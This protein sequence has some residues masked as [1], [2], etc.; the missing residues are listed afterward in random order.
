MNSAGDFSLSSSS[1]MPESVTGTITSEIEEWDDRSGNGSFVPSTQTASTTIP[2]GKTESP[3]VAAH[4]QLTNLDRYRGASATVSMG[5]SVVSKSG[6]GPFEFSRNN[7]N[8]SVVYDIQGGSGGGD[9][10][11]AIKF[12]GKGKIGAANQDAVINVTGGNGYSGSV[13]L[14][15]SNSYKATL[16]NL[17]CGWSYTYTASAGCFEATFDPVSILK[18]NGSQS[19]S[20]NFE[21][22]EDCEDNNCTINL[23]GD[24]GFGGQVN[25][26]VNLSGGASKSVTLSSSNS[27]K[28]TWSGMACGEKY[29]VSATAELSS[30]ANK[31]AWADAVLSATAEPDSFTLNE[32]QD[33]YIKITDSAVQDCGIEVQGTGD[34]GNGVFANI[35]LSGGAS[36]TATLDESNNYLAT[37]TGLTCGKSYTVSVTKAGEKKNGAVTTTKVT[38]T[39]NPSGAFT[40]TGQANDVTKYVTV[41]FKKD[42][43]P[44]AIK[45]SIRYKNQIESGIAT[46]ASVTLSGN[47][48]SSQTKTLAGEFGD[49]ITFSDLKPGTYSLSFSGASAGSG[50]CKAGQPTPELSTTSPVVTAG[51]TTEV[52][53]TYVCPD[54]GSS[55]IAYLD[56]GF[57]SG[58]IGAQA[59]CNAGIPLQAFHKRAHLSQPV[60]QYVEIHV[61]ITFRDGSGTP[62]YAYVGVPISKGSTSGSNAQTALN[63][64]YCGLTLVGYEIYEVTHSDE[65][66]IIW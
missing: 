6:D 60:S 63:F 47:G 49:Y 45:V 51:K 62:H 14:N 15:K 56:S 39:V 64:D 55:I 43:G 57:V 10:T 36:K 13:T 27:Y 42:E 52:T 16:N 34:T 46:T 25:A 8:Y 26:K 21:M 66:G 12:T 59:N 48:T 53:L 40:I 32:E 19:V 11:C 1:E 41:D 2:A 18:L 61:R 20:V 54:P 7:V 22:G 58:V 30:S 29:T 28:A 65:L 17:E 24:G 3:V 31:E 23:I 5:G 50:Y 33:V 37:W 9:P 35:S 4:N 44:G 38:A